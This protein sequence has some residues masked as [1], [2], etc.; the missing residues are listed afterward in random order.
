MCWF[1][2]CHHDVWISCCR[3][4]CMFMF[5]YF[6][7]LF[8]LMFMFVCSCLFTVLSCSCFFTLDVCSCSCSCLFTVLSCSCSCLRAC[9]RG[10]TNGVPFA[11]QSRIQ[12]LCNT[13]MCIYRYMCMYNVTHIQVYV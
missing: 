10:C 2:R 13:Y 5:V 11:A 9:H 3:C 7:L 4:I 1:L 12:P 6:M 8:M